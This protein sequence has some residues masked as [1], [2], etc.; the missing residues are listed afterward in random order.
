MLMLT[1]TL[2]RPAFLGSFALLLTVAGAQAQTIPATSSTATATTSSSD[3]T[4]AFALVR[5]PE[6]PVKL[7]E[8]P[9]PTEA[10][11]FYDDSHKDLRQALTWMTETNAVAPKY[12]NVYTESRIRLKLKDYAGARTAAEQAKKLALAATPPN[13]EYAQLSEAVAAQAQAGAK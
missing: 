4:Y 11:S 10:A 8:I 6:A 2:F 12:W 1:S 5:H 9:A 13:Q 3:G 7:S